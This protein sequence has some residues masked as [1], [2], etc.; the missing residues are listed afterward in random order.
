[1]IGK[2]DE[3]LFAAEQGR[4]QT[5]SDT[6]LTQYKLPASLSATTI[7]TKDVISRLF[8][9]LSPPILFLATEGLTINNWFLRKGEKV[10][11]RKGRLDGDI[12]HK[13]PIGALLESSLDKIGA[14]VTAVSYTHLTLP[15]K[16]EV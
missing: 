8:I 7:D 4:A 9:E 1:M 16:L 11:F 6:L 3:A 10:A 14:D 13:D 5:L 15:T 12:R 2:V